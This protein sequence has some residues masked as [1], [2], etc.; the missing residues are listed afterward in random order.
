MKANEI[1]AGDHAA[2][3]GHGFKTHH[4]GKCGR[5]RSHPDGAQFYRV[6]HRAGVCRADGRHLVP[7]P[8]PDLET[9][10]PPATA[11]ISIP[12]TRVRR[13]YVYLAPGEYQGNTDMLQIAREHIKEHGPRDPDTPLMV[14]VH[15]HAGWFESFVLLT[16]ADES[17]VCRIHTANDRASYP[18][19]VEAVQMMFASLPVKP[20]VRTTWRRRPAA[21]G[22]GYYGD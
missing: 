10:M 5:V 15:E 18:K 22:G 8:S 1:K 14:T 13:H 17:R 6:R 11:K 3:E 21:S 20:E 9:E 12:V 19:E 4:E 7:L 2:Y 16:I